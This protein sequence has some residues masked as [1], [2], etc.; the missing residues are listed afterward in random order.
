MITVTRLDGK[1]LVVNCDQILQVESTPD[2]VLLLTTGSHLMVRES[3]NQIVDSVVAFR[4]RIARA[5]LI[6][7][8]KRAEE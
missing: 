7:E 4:Q 1:Q 6:A 2:T 3:V 5:P 8:Q